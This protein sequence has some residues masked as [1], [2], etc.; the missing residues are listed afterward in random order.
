MEQ[1]KTNSTEQAEKKVV[2]AAAPAIESLFNP[3]AREK[4]WEAGFAHNEVL[5]EQI[6][7]RQ[8]LITDVELITKKLPNPD[9]S[10]QE[11]L[12]SNL[13]DE[14]EVI[15][16]L[17]SI[18]STLESGLN[19]ERFILYL[20]FGFLPDIS[21][22]PESIKLK[23]EIEHFRSAYMKAWNNLLFSHDVRANFVDGDVPEVELR[24]GDLPRVVKAAHL[25][26]FLVQK[27]F[28]QTDEVLALLDTTKDSILRQNIS[29]ALF[30]MAD[31]GLITEEKI[32]DGLLIEK[33]TDKISVVTERRKKWLEE[34]EKQKSA[35]PLTEP[36][37]GAER[38]S[39]SQ[40]KNF[41]EMESEAKEVKDIVTQIQ[42]D[43]R[44]SKLFYPVVILS[45]SRLKG[46]GGP[47]SDIDFGIF[48]K[49]SVDANNRTDVT[50]AIREVFSGIKNA[51]DP[52]EFWLE[53][54][55]GQL[56]VKNW[57]EPNPL[58]GENFQV[59]LLLGAVWE[60]NGEAVQNLREKLLTPYFYKTDTKIHNED[61]R[62]M[63]LG[64][65][66]RDTLQYRLMHKGYERFFPKTVGIKTAHSDYIDGQSMFWDS[67]YRQLATKLFAQRIFLP[68]LLK[69]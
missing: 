39:N 14:N 10:L 20:P 33:I 4:N 2:S 46:Y 41:T 34:K 18:S 3:I 58:L 27:G 38:L 56:S 31:L 30:V 51:S 69:K 17:S 37:I 6:S 26:P 19:Y 50:K 28:M 36:Q 11:A 45:G 66:E 5:I 42:N 29:E 25:I 61:A 43:E 55:D 48:V 13:I 60:G 63:Y 47:D 53:E 67:G 62:K 7:D 59:Q 49:P 57:T 23:S 15:N 52:V 22:R 12:E 68:Q 65:L 1:E 8:K 24:D 16:V 40:I 35:E 9:M 64:E 32:P 54:N 44:L 21:W